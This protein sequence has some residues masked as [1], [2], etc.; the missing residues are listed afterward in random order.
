MSALDEIYSAQTELKA[1]MAQCFTFLN[2]LPPAQQTKGIGEAQAARL[3]HYFAQADENNA[4]ARKS[5]SKKPEHV[6]FTEK[7]MDGIE[8]TYYCTRGSF[9]DY[10]H[11]LEIARAAAAPPP[12]TLNA[13]MSETASAISAIYKKLPSMDLEPFSGKH[14]DWEAFRDLFRNIVHRCEK[15]SAIDKFLFL[16]ARV[17]GKALEIIEQHPLGGN[18]Y[19]AAWADLVKYYENPRRLLHTHLSTFFSAKKMKSYTYASLSRLSSE[20]FVP[21]NALKALQRPVDN[22]SDMLVF[23]ITSRFETTTFVEWQKSL[24][25]QTDPPTLT[26]LKAFMETQMCTLEGMEYG[27]NLQITSTNNPPK[28]PKPAQSHQAVN[29]SYEQE[30]MISKC[31]LCDRA[32]HIL[33]ACPDFRSKSVGERS[34]FV[35]QRK[36]CFNCLGPHLI[37][38]C[39]SDKRCRTCKNKHNTLLHRKKTDDTNSFGGGKTAEIS[40]SACTNAQSSEPAAR[41]VNSAWSANSLSAQMEFPEFMYSG[42]TPVKSPRQGVLLAT[43]Y[44][45]VISDEGT[46]VR[47][48][49]LIDPCSQASFVSEALSKKLKLANESVQAPISGTGGELVAVCNKQVTLSIRPHFDS[50]YTHKLEALVLKKVSSYVPPITNDL[51]EPNHL[52]GLQ[53]ADPRFLDDFPVEVLLG[54]GFYADIVQGGMLKGQLNEPIAVQ[55][56]LG[57]I[58][59]GN[60]PIIGAPINTHLS[61]VDPL[62]ELTKKFWEIEE[63]PRKPV[64][65][66]E[67]LQCEDLFIS[68]HSRDSTGRFTVRLPFKDFD[69]LKSLN[70]GES[71]DKAIRMLFSMEGKFRRDERLKHEYHA[72]LREFEELGHMQLIST[73]DKSLD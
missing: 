31:V 21:L 36:L 44:I 70:L 49:A 65:S 58:V 25:D 4:K 11:E 68:T 8:D 53:L 1:K 66:E 15:L 16:K 50:H 34:E 9:N 51:F 17:R 13:T 43:A 29:Q 62:Y 72:F 6:Y 23:F 19:E 46:V 69:S 5:Q 14:C 2:E 67:D 3:E 48:R 55:T 28:G 38:N 54:T 56:T 39:T 60:V 12:E 37:R 26:Q 35:A 40:H 20:V 24:G 33:F 61:C 22:W 27:Q 71:K 18:H 30:A 73:F 10:F 42:N 57:W 64:Q 47:V 45:R 7:V 41:S 52:Q 63:V 32:D 59:W